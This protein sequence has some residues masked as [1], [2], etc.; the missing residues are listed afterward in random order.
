MSE[1]INQERCFPDEA[2]LLKEQGIPLPNRYS[3][4]LLSPEALTEDFAAEA[5]NQLLEVRKHAS[6]DTI[7]AQNAAE[8]EF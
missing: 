3:G 4:P 2:L 8:A 7:D 6:T 1:K 5:L